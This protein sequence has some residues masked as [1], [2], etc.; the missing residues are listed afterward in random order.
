MPAFS[1]TSRATRPTP[2]MSTPTCR[3][4]LGP[5]GACTL[6]DHVRQVLDGEE[7]DHV[8]RMQVAA[9]LVHVDLGHDLLQLLEPLLADDLVL[10]AE[11]VVRD[12]SL[13]VVG[14]IR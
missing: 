10:V 13:H 3:R 8:L 14:E 4:R 12:P 9:L 6:I 1:V 5:C 2:T 11:L 7:L